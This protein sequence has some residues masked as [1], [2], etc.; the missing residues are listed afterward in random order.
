[1]W[2]RLHSTQSLI[3]YP[4]R[5]SGAISLCHF[6]WYPSLTLLRNQ[7]PSLGHHMATIIWCFARIKPAWHLTLHYTVTWVVKKLHNA[8]KLGFKHWSPYG[9]NCFMWL[10]WHKAVSHLTSHYSTTKAMAGAILDG[11]NASQCGETQAPRIGHDRAT[12]ISCNASCTNLPHT[13]HPI[14]Q[15]HE[16][17]TVAIMGGIQA[18]QCWEIR[19]QALIT[20]KQQSFDLVQVAF[21][22]ITNTI[23]STG[24]W[25]HSL[26]Q[27]W[28]LSKPHNA[29][30]SGSKPWSPYLLQQ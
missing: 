9:N 8:E 24:N 12:I 14:T 1:M 20:I 27:L 28:G 15:Q 16:P 5:L 2:C 17:S 11:N 3:T 7:A 4:Q 19:L 26:V 10:W 29:E 30:K 13:L 6:L 23:S 25:I 22:P 18:S 21:N